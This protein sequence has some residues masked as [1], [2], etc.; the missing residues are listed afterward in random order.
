[1]RLGKIPLKKKWLQR[2][3]FAL[4]IGGLILTVPFTNWTEQASIA[5]FCSLCLGTLATIISSFIPNN[6][7][8]EVT[9]DSWRQLSDRPE[10]RIQIPAKDHGF[11]RNPNVSLYQVEGNRNALVV[12]EVSHDKHGNIDVNTLSRFKGKALVS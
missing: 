10:Y 3:S 6:Y 4:L 11:G 12:V 1:M 7:T 2:L 5:G 9:E 8:L